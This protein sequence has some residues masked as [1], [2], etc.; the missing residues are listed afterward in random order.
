M[1]DMVIHHGQSFKKKKKARTGMDLL[2]GSLS[3]SPALLC[4]GVERRVLCVSGLRGKGTG[5]GLL[6]AGPTSSLLSLVQQL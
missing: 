1:K 3:C 4:L 6:G 5:S 2:S